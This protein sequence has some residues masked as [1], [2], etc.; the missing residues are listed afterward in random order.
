VTNDGHGRLQDDFGL[1]DRSQQPEK[2]GLPGRPLHPARSI[3][4]AR[5]AHPESTISSFAVA[6]LRSITMGPD[7]TS[8]LAKIDATLEPYSGR[9]LV[10][11]SGVETLE[12][13][14]TGDLVIVEFPDRDA[15]RA[16]YASEAYQRIVRLRT[17]N[18]E[19]AVIL[20]DGVSEPHRASDILAPTQRP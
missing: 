6:H 17:E 14:W 2:A 12:G 13:I 10:H 3:R 9:F 19:G 18:S 16:W 15:A 7:I 4:Q 1:L 11:G 5:Q 8:Y 20:V